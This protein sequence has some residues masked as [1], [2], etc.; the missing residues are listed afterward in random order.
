MSAMRT[1]TVTDWQPNNRPVFGLSTTA[2]IMKSTTGCW[3]RVYW[4][5]SKRALTSTR[6]RPKKDINFAT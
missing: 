5:F 2:A 3:Q 1:R 4:T 6:F